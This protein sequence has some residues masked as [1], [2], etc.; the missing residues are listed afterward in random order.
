MWRLIYG[1]PSWILFELLNIPL[2]ILGWVLIPIAAACKA[3]KPDLDF[4]MSYG[5]LPGVTAKGDDVKY[6]FTWPFMFLW[7]NYEDGIANDTYWKAPNMFLQIV[8]W[9]A[10]RNPTNNLRIV[11]YLSCKLNPEKIGFRGSFIS[12]DFDATDPVPEMAATRFAYKLATVNKYDTKIPQWFF[13]WQGFYTNFYWQFNLG[14]KLRRFWIG[15]KIYPTTIYKIPEYQK[16][17][18]GFALQWKVVK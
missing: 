5:D 14:G 8:Y 1:I 16:N 17:G 10:N 4:V 12:S 2:I 15:W 6:H 9:S 18:A 7:D 3:Y 13:A 11:P